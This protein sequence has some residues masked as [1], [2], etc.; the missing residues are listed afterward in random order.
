MDGLAVRIPGNRRGARQ[1]G[2]TDPLRGQE[3][4][5]I[6]HFLGITLWQELCIFRV[7]ISKVFMSKFYNLSLCVCAGA[8]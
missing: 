4:K 2:P 6:F 5:D 7:Q 3:I 8:L 1:C